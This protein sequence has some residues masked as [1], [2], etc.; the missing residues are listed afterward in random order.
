MSKY[1]PSLKG[2][3][4]LFEVNYMLLTRLLG[5]MDAVGDTK[6]FY[7]TQG[8]AFQLQVEQKSKYT[9]V[10]RFEQIQHQDSRWSEKL[11]YIS[12]AIRLYHDARLAEVIEY[13]NNKNVKPRY[14]YPN[15]G[16]HLPDEK[17]QIHQFLTQWLQVCLQQGKSLGELNQQGD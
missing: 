9:H 15:K 14:D 1:H 7:L 16:M 12:M 6:Q 11:P 17:K 4:N 10:V 5:G 8:L 2:L 13:Q 3:I